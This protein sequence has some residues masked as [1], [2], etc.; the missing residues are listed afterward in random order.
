MKRV[1][2][3]IFFVLL[4]L[5]AEG[6]TFCAEL[7]KR[8]AREAGIALPIAPIVQSVR[9]QGE[10]FNRECPYYIYDDGVVSAERSLVGCVATSAEQVVSHYAYPPQLLDSIAGF[11]SKNNG[12]IATIPS[13]TELDFDNILSIYEEGLY[14]ADEAAAVAELSYML[15]V[16]CRMNWAVGASGA[17]VHRLVEP[18][19]RAFGYGYV[20]Y[21]CS[22][23][24][25]PSRWI[26][27]LLT[28]LASG[29]PIVYAGYSSSGSGHAFVIDGV[30]SDGRFH[31]SW[32]F[33]GH[34]DGYF[35]LAL[36]N[37]NE[38]PLEP[39]PEGAVESYSHM[40]EA[41]FLHPD[42][43]DYV[44]D[45]TLPLAHRV[46]VDTVMFNRVPDTNMYTVAKVKLR[47]ISDTDVFAPVELFTYSELDSLGNP[48]DMDYL[49]MVDAVL[50]VGADTMLLA[51]VHFTDTG[52]RLLGLNLPDTMYLPFD[53]LTVLPAS[54]PK[55]TYALADSVITATSASFS[56]SI[57]NQSELYWSGRMVTY[58][59]FEGAYTEQENDL[60]HYRVLNLAPSMTTTDSISFRHLT[61]DTDYT[62]VVRNPWQPA[63]TVEFHTPLVTGL[64]ALEQGSEAVSGKADNFGNKLRSY[65]INHRI[66][67]EYDESTGRYR[68]VLF[69]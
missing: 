38:S 57:A 8:V 18:L 65:R 53:T 21:L 62:F 12:E 15:G 23:D 29:R 63:L 66:T 40:Q 31:A 6:Q 58:S 52:S 54:Q 26:R 46:E 47:N 44:V 42:S 59:I 33:G 1:G 2:F 22:Y 27:L 3:Y 48:A 7:V 4:T 24:Y 64:N 14:S 68:Q 32:G 50:E 35:D 60:R 25:A 45:D 19:K 34:N 17:Q 49:G 36:L 20:R 67:I 56:L 16:A 13:G 51:Y 41:L 9:S 10:P 69:R 5:G 39:T 11:S 37:K 61:P 55:L 30:S 43:V 28:E